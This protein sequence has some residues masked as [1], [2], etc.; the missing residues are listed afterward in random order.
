MDHEPLI[1]RP[2][3]RQA[4]LHVVGTIVTVLTSNQQTGSMGFTLQSGAEGT[5]PPPHCHPWDE[6]FYVL[7]GSVEFETRGDRVL[8]EAGTLVHVPGGTTHAFSYG[9][10]GGRMLEITGPGSCAALMFGDFDR[11]MRGEPEIG[12]VAEIFDRHSVKLMA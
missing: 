5:G 9:P 7:E 11:E 2:A 10:G 8:A 4:P 3:D 12:K 6:A 1:I